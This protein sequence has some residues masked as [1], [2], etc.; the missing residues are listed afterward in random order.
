MV[1][2]ATILPLIAAVP[3]RIT[4]HLASPP[5]N[6]TPR[7][8]LSDEAVSPGL[9]STGTCLATGSAAES[10]SAALSEHRQPVPGQP[11]Q[12]SSKRTTGGRGEGRGRRSCQAGDRPWTFIC[13]RLG[14]LSVYC[15]TLE[16]CQCGPI[17]G[18][19]ILVITSGASVFRVC[20]IRDSSRLTSSH[21]T[22][23]ME[24]QVRAPE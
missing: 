23:S 19:V 13:S 15:E 24:S 21:F 12:P 1:S 20:L 18:A 7:A 8:T 4:S 6:A 5:A 22:P 17:P 11:L 9:R 3:G 16:T 2:P 10:Q 14:L